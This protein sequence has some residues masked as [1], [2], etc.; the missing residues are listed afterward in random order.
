MSK[1]LDNIADK[2]KSVSVEDIHNESEQV[3]IMERHKQK[4]NECQG[5]HSLDHATSSFF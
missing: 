1:S 3:C 4:L 5:R 2:L